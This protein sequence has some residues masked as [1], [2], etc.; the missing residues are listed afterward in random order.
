MKWESETI[1]EGEKEVK[2]KEN[3]GKGKKMEGGREVAIEG[4]NTGRKGVT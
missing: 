3:R 1:G 4:D 2:K